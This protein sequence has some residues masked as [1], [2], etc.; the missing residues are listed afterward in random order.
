M[1][2]VHPILFPKP[3]LNS[4]KGLLERGFLTPSFFSA[5]LLAPVLPKQFETM[6]EKKEARI[7]LSQGNFRDTLY[8]RSAKAHSNQYTPEAFN[9]QWNM[10]NRSHTLHLTSA[11][12]IERV[13]LISKTPSDLYV[14]HFV[15]N[16][17]DAMDFPGMVQH[18]QNKKFSTH[19]HIFWNYPG[20][21]ASG[22]FSLSVYEVIA[23]GL[24]Q[25]ESLLAR[26]VPVQ[27]ITLYGRSI[28][29][30]FASQ[31]AS[32]LLQNEY[33]PHLEID[34]SFASISA[35]PLV[36]VRRSLD[37]NPRLRPFYSAILAFSLLGLSSGFVVS[38][39]IATIGLLCATLI[40][41]VGYIMANI[42]QTIRNGLEL[43]LPVDSAQ[44]LLDWFDKLT[45]AIDTK[46]AG[47]ALLVHQ[48]IF[49]VLASILGLVTAIPG[50]FVGSV[51]GVGIGA[52]LSLQ[53]PFT[54]RPPLF[55]PLYYAFK[56]ITFVAHIEM[57]SVAAVEH[58]LN[59][60]AHLPTISSTNTED[61]EIIPLAASLNKGL[62][63]D[64]VPSDSVSYNTQCN[65]FW[66]KRGGHN[67]EIRVENLGRQYQN[68]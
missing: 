13:E 49:N 67:A 30:G 18:V 9:Y 63:F 25:V 54:D 24:E 52:I 57:N 62:G 35:I 15:G 19:N 46:I 3:I 6:V 53:T 44:S 39:L 51:L 43:L 59:D 38:G 55:F 47:F 26:G 22:A 50:L 48:H 11:E 16:A 33:R 64:S 41:A 58:I 17:Q 42:V 32:R 36:G 12:G 21:E 45:I 2:S 31:V 7:A 29:G 56:W 27:N 66:Y 68:S 65:F 1:P 34:R 14:L 5:L 4:F 60:T 28:G 10:V 40:A 23:A 8:F 61:D 37:A 20:V